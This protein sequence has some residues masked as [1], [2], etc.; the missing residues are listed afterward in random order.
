MFTNEM[1]ESTEN[2]VH[3]PSVEPDSMNVILDYAYN[4][5]VALAK[6]NVLEIYRSG[7]L[8]HVRSSD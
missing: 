6:E 1:K 5:M 7:Q 8:L 3:L 2:V 4:G